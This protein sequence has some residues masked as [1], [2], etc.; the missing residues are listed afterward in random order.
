MTSGGTP[1]TR[2]VS[3]DCAPRQLCWRPPSFAHRV[4]R[5]EPVKLRLLGDED[6]Q[7]PLLKGSVDN[8]DANV[9]NIAG[10][11]REVGDHD[12]RCRAALVDGSSLSDHRRFCRRNRV[13]ASQPRCRDRGG[14]GHASRPAETRQPGDSSLL[15]KMAPIEAFEAWRLSRSKSPCASGKPLRA[16]ASAR[17]AARI[18]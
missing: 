5:S 18:R 9:S 1:S 16:N 11:A 10:L 7:R 13:F 3:D 15:W 2:M 17:S 8:L 14:P 6:R 12:A 4:R